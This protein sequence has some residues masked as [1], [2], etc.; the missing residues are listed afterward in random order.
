MKKIPLALAIL[1]GLALAIYLF[2]PFKRELTDVQTYPAPRYPS[3]VASQP[4]TLGDEPLRDLARKVVRS[5]E[6]ETPLGVVGAGQKVLL[7]MA[8]D[9]TCISTL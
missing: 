2:S 7:R 6:G 9:F 3:Y 5:M 8:T 4:Q 1:A